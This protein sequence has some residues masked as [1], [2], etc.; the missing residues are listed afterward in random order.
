MRSGDVLVC[1]VVKY[2]C[3]LWDGFGN[4]CGDVLV[5]VVVMFMLW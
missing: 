2:W 4:G 5:F 1:D 3:V